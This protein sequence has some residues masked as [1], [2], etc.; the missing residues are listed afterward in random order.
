M[1][2]AL[3]CC[4]DVTRFVHNEDLNLPQI[5]CIRGI[6]VDPHALCDDCRRQILSPQRQIARGRVRVPRALIRAAMITF[7]VLA[8]FLLATARFT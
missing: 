2:R 7:A 3:L 6:R 5:A 4:A 8:I 1:A